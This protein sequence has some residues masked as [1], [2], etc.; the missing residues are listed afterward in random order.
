[1]VVMPDLPTDTSNLFAGSGRCVGC[2]EATAN[3]PALKSPEGADISPPTLWRS[4]MMA[5][6][7]KDPLW[8][9]KVTAEIADNPA[10]KET[11]EDKCTACHMPMGHTEAIFNGA[12]TYT[13]QE[14]LNDPLA[15]DGVSCTLCHQIESDG[16]GTAG[17]FSGNYVIKDNELLYGPYDD[18]T[19]S[20]L[21]LSASGYG[22]EYGS[23]MEQSEL[24]ATCH[25]LFTPTV[26]KAG[27]LTGGSIAEQTPYLEWKNSDY[28]AQDI[29]CQTCHV[30]QILDP[31]AIST[32]PGGLDGKSPFGLHHF[33]GGNTFILE[34][35]KANG[36]V[37]GVTA[38]AVHF[39][40]TIARTRRQL[41]RAA[42]LSGT[43]GWTNGGDT[44]EVTIRVQNLTGHK[45]PT[46][47]PSRRSWLQLKLSANDGTTVFE[48]GAWDASGEI[49]GLS[50]PFEPHRDVI[51][52]SSQT[53]IYQSL[54]AD[55]DG[56][57][58]WILLRGAEYAKDNRI[59]PAGFVASGP[60]YDTTAVVGAAL[61]DLNFNRDGAV[62]GS[63]SDAV[64]YRIGG[65]DQNQGYSLD[66]KLQYQSVAPAFVSDLSRHSTPEVNTF[67]TYYAAADNSPVTID[68][69]DIS[70]TGTST[71]GPA[72]VPRTLEILE[73]YPNPAVESA[74]VRFSLVAP[75]PLRVK[76]VDALG[77]TVRT[78]THGTL[79]A[80]AHTLELDLAGLSSGLYF[81]QV[82]NKDSSS[83][84]RLM[85]IR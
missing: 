19:Y 35:L 54:M 50:K 82:E 78:T 80:G 62:E 58:T 2:H 39:D 17:S 27:N 38:D 52:T 77:R 1:M 41:A 12:T 85:V 24:C 6:A 22:F 16:L 79:G 63:G 44:L 81:V 15:L 84:T 10:L 56:D 34:M 11:I 14:G 76:I 51:R 55:V 64:T 9:A 13:L 72:E 37:I 36:D 40:S 7:A 49:V 75:S 47:F 68:S 42:E 32:V 71:E 53:A 18:E 28:P 4:T 43:Y 60:H 65:L 29:Q 46:G 73:V 48:S 57:I 3:S 45:F 5:N 83:T 30:P 31:V 69:L 20:S 67:N 33:V 66:V 61:A 70:V 23:Q 59:P 21:M 8:L 26:D 74:S 25:T